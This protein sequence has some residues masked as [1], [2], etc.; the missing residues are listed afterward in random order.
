MRLSPRPRSL[1]TT[2]VSGVDRL[3]T[4]RADAVTDLF[5]AH[6]RRLV[7]TAALLVD[8]RETAEDV[9]MDAFLGLYRRWTAIRDPDAAYGYVRSAVLN[10]AR[11]QLRR[12][13]V[14]RLHERAQPMAEPTTT[15][16]ASQ[17]A[18]VMQQLRALPARQRQVLVLRYYLD[19]SEAEI[20]SQLRISPGSV[21][22]HA[23]RG[24]AALAKTL[25]GTR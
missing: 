9:V 1:D 13:R 24:L 6:Y 12:R 8:D 23:S 20:A 18:S 11:S 25:E 7:R 16:D 4:D 19:L 21:K 15:E 22:T 10:G 5:D 3:S 14:S 17:R 2:L